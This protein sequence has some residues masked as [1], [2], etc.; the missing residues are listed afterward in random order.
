[1]NAAAYSQQ[2]VIGLSNGLLF[3]LIA[4]GY[5]LVYSVLG[6]V[7]FAHGDVF[8]LAAMA[9]WL[10]MAQLPE[11]VWRGTAC[12]PVL[13]LLTV[14]A[15]AFG[16]ALNVAINAVVYRPIRRGSALAPL[17]AAVGASLALQNVG[18]FVGGL[19]QASGGAQA[20]AAPKTFLQP[21][22]ASNVLPE[23]FGV[24]VSPREIFTFCVTAIALW[25]VSA[26]VHRSR[27]GRAL[28]AVAEDPTA[29]SLMGIDAERTVTHAFALAG[30]LAGV[31]ALTY[32]LF[33][34]TVHYQMGFQNGL[35]AFSAAV[36]GGLGSL[37]G[38]VI[39]AVLLGLLR[40]GCDVWLGGQW[41]PA[42]VFGALLL[43]LVVRPQGLFGR[44]NEKV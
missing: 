6:L 42:I 8:M 11:W 12:W 4:L 20:A 34:G 38:A 13:L 22:A 33:V 26:M 28:R 31:A 30:A 19:S 25:A 41:Q 3:A 39:G 5:S 29:A 43:L 37:G 14:G 18:L 40:A 17:V 44:G 32:G 2:L 7:N 36:T 16:A 1:M 21:L 23:S 27:F 15:A 9:S 10:T 35:Y 24:R